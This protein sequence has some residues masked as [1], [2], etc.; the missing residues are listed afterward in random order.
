MVQNVQLMFHVQCSILSF[1]AI[2]CSSFRNVFSTFLHC[3]YVRFS[4]LFFRLPS[5]EA[6]GLVFFFPVSHFAHYHRK[7][8]VA[9]F[10]SFRYYISFYCHFVVVSLCSKAIY[11]CSPKINCEMTDFLCCCFHLCDV[12]S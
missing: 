3:F 6:A 10:V 4:L 5:D 9:L 12:L 11:S 2:R 7:A 8:A 1:V